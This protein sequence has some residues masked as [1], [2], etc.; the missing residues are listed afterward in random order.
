MVTEPELEERL[1]VEL[2]L[3]GVDLAVGKTLDW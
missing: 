1:P 3:G 2:A